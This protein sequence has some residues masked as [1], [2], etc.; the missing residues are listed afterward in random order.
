MRVVL[1]SFL[2][3]VSF[4]F[5]Y[6]I[7]IDR[8]RQCSYFAEFGYAYPIETCTKQHFGNVDNI[9]AKS[10]SMIY[11][12]IEK[13]ENQDFWLI[14]EHSFDNSE[15]VGD[16][17]RIERKRCDDS[18]CNCYGKTEYCNIAEI[19]DYKQT[20]KNCTDSIISKYIYVID[21]CIN[22]DG[23][24]STKLQCDDKNHLIF[25]KL[26]STNSDCNS[27]NNPSIKEYNDSCIKIS[28]QYVNSANNIYSNTSIL[29][30]ILTL[31]VSLNVY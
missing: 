17:R 23:G 24:Y 31:I 11:H 28:C 14:E 16:P 29:I 25:D 26:Y 10:S 30:A 22:Y 27:I 12:C 7:N 1:I 9:D 20:K 6:G 21:Q 3:L 4:L 5:G 8:S 13:I 2:I 18:Y 15:C 19:I